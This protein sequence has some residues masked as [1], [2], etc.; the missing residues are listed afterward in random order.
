MFFSLHVSNLDTIYCFVEQKSLAEVRQSL[1]KRAKKY[2]V[3]W[4]HGAAISDTFCVYLE[5]KNPLQISNILE[6]ADD[7]F[8]S[9][10]HFRYMIKG[11]LKGGNS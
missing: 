1:L 5:K 11:F 4:R 7:M 6:E 2:D 8:K 3:A 9:I 10:V